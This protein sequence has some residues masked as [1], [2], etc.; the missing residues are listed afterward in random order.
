MKCRR[1]AESTD[2]SLNGN[3]KGGQKIACTVCGRGVYRTPRRIKNNQFC[4]IACYAKWLEV[5]PPEQA[6]NFQNKLIRTECLT[7]NKELFS[8]GRKKY[9]S[10]KCRAVF[11][12]KKELV[13]CSECGNVFD[14]CVS[15]IKWTKVRGGRNHFCTNECK[16]KF[17]RGE[18]SG[19]WIADRSLLKDRNRSIRYSIDMSEWR[20]SVFKRDEYKCQWCGDKS[21]AGNPVT[22]NAH[23]I[24]P[25]AKFP[26]LRFAVDNGITLC[27]TCHKKTYKKEDELIIFF[28]EVLIKL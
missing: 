12:S 10:H 28:E 18:N 9:C 6:G 3:Y 14:R 15:K 5:L 17:Q 26:A 20:K 22:L 8:Y 25:F 4:S 24:R 27:E 11:H 21:V 7:C 2:P 16:I 19:R 1:D 23:H 13:H